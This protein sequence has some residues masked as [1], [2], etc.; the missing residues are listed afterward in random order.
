VEEV[1]TMSALV[2]VVRRSKDSIEAIEEYIQR[3]Q[4]TDSQDPMAPAIAGG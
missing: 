1:A 2:T 3:E 4:S